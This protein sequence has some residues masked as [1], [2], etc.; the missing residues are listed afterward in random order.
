MSACGITRHF[1]GTQQTRQVMMPFSLT[2]C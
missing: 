1:E 2:A